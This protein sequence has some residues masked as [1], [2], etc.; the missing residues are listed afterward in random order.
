[1]GCRLSYRFVLP[2]PDDGPALF[3]ESVVHP[4]VADNV[5][6]QLGRPVVVVRGWGSVVLGTPMSKASINEDSYLAAREHHVGGAA[7]LPDRSYVHS[8]TKTPTMKLTS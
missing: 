1:V 7:N 3:P 8:V 2:H 5:A 4:T 6:S